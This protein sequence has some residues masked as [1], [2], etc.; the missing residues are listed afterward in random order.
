MELWG[1]WGSRS[2]KKWEKY[3]L[4][5]HREDSNKLKS[6]VGGRL[7]NIIVQSLEF[8]VE[9]LIPESYFLS[10]ANTA[11][12]PAAGWCYPEECPFCIILTGEE[13][14]ARVSAEEARIKSQ[15]PWM[16]PTGSG[17]EAENPALPL[18]LAV[19]ACCWPVGEWIT[20]VTQT[21]SS[22]KAVL[23]SI[24]TR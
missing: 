10:P 11:Y 12:M 1:R 22:S 7:V 14:R 9:S 16:A 20:R 4:E 23:C 17:Q 21:Q 2:T 8:Y 19:A 3:S 13:K 15:C 18:A 24:C 5:A 6:D